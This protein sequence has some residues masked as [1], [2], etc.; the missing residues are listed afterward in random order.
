MKN[1]INMDLIVGYSQRKLQDLE[2]HLET[3][4]DLVED[5]FRSVLTEFNPSFNTYE[6][7]PGI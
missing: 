4:D 7:L 5:D 1:E 2:F 3:E 6:K